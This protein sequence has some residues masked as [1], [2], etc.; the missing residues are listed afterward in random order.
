VSNSQGRT[1]TQVLTHALCTATPEQHTSSAAYF[2]GAYQVSA[3]ERMSRALKR[4]APSRLD[5]GQEAFPLLYGSEEVPVS[6]TPATE[7]AA[8]AKSSPGTF[9]DEEGR[10]VPRCACGAYGMFGV[11]VSLRHGR[12]GSVGV[13]LRHGREGTW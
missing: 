12:E 2:A 7:I 11:G 8:S 9:Y 6:D 1:S 3:A 4:V 5:E 13:S 10:F